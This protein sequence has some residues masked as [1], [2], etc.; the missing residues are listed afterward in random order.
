MAIVIRPYRHS[1]IPFLKEMFYQSLFVPKDQPPFD[2]SVLDKPGLKKYLENWGRPTD[3][4]F[5][6]IDQ[7]QCIGAIWSRFFTSADPGYGFVKSEY[8]ELGIALISKYRNKGIGSQ[9]IQDLL[10][11]LKQN[12]VDGVS[13]SVDA[14]NPAFRLYKRLGFTETKKDGD[15]MTM[16]KHWCSPTN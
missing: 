2:K 12:K 14:R 4:G 8:P 3:Y 10:D 15:S 16:V 11:H 9:L 5:V 13:L 6:A 1:D 7:E